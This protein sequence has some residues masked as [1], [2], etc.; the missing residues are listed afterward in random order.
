MDDAKSKECDRA[1]QYAGKPLPH[2]QSLALL[3]GFIEL[4]RAL[5]S[6]FYRNSPDR[7]NAADFAR[8]VIPIAVTRGQH[9]FV[10]RLQ[11][12]AGQY[13]LWNYGD[14]VP[15]PHVENTSHANLDM[16]Y[17]NVLWQSLGRL[18]A[19]VPPG[20]PIVLDGI[21]RKRFANTFLQQIARAQEIDRRGNLR[22]DV[23]GRSAE[24]IAGQPDYYNRSWDGWVHLA[25]A[26]ARV[27]RLCRDVGLRTDAK[28]YSQPY[29][30]VANHSALLVNK[31]WTPTAP[32]TECRPGYKCCVSAPDGSC[33]SCVPQKAQC[34]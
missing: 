24:D 26:D 30:T 19:K 17:L 1:G 14:D 21:I 25:S 20:E 18:S 6:D 15:N 29:L 16:L 34:P 9:Y 3:M 33:R 23:S 13:Y 2:N 31:R 27:Y 22:G 5:D 10:D 8:G 12:P 11:L 7:V 32:P 28:G 4:W